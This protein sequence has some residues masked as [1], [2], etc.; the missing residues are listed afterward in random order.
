MGQPNEVKADDLSQ[1]VLSLPDPG[2]LAC[3]LLG[4]ALDDEDAFEYVSLNWIWH[5]TERELNRIEAYL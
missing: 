2:N 4:L 1:H 3:G 5:C